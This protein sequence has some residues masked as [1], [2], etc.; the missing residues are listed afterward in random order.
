MVSAD[1]GICPQAIYKYSLSSESQLP[2]HTLPTKQDRKWLL[3]FDF[4]IKSQA[5]VKCTCRQLV[6]TFESKSF[7]LFTPLQGLG[8]SILI[9][10]RKAEEALRRP[11]K[12]QG[13][14]GAP[15]GTEGSCSPYNHIQAS[16]V[17]RGPAV[18]QTPWLT[19]EATCKKIMRDP[20]L[21]RKQC[22]GSPRV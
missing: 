22:Q 11:A 6:T 19:T 14:M 9:H 18:Q 15:G 7:P 12:N 3:G 8:Y 4:R 10:K 16:W 20:Q 17:G 1:Q 2:D 5:F 13:D 21:E